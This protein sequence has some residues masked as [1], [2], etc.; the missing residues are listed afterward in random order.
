MSEI[1]RQQD[2]VDILIVGGGSAGCVLAARLSE[3]P[4][5]IVRLLEAGEV[6]PLNSV[7]ADLLD[8]A[9]VPGEPRHDWGYTMRGSAASPAI[10]APR[11][12][13]LGGSSA[14]NAAVAMRATADD[15]RKWKR[16]NL[17]GWSVEEVAAV[18]KSMESAPDG[19]PA[20]HGQTGP[21][22]IRQRTYSGL[23]SS[24]KAF[25]DAGTAA[26]YQSVDDFSSDRH[27]GIGGFPVNVVDGRRQ[28]TAMT[29]LTDA[30]R[31][32]PN[33]TIDGGVLIDRV[34]F[35]DGVA[36]G[37]IDAD[38][39]VYRASEVIL[40][41][42]AYASPA[43]LLRSGV[44]AA[45]ELTQLG[46]SVVADLPVGQRL[47]DHPFYYNASALK[48][49]HLDMT[50]ATGALLWTASSESRGEELD[51]HITATHLFD[52]SLSPTGGAIAIGIAVVSPDSRGT[53]RLR[54]R[55]PREHPVIDSNF[56]REE[57]DRRRMLEG[58]KLSRKL[59]QSPQLGS[60][61]AVE[62]QPGA[63]V[64]GN[65][66][67]SNAIDAG[68]APY[69]HPAS[70]APMGGPE[71]PW[72]VVG[73]DGAVKGVAGLRVIDASIMPEI[74]TVA[75]HLTVIMIAERLAR[76]VYGALPAR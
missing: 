7:P 49:E 21:F 5:R 56:L 38:G 12:K 55:D 52:H 71:D 62:L 45:D 19:A 27:H 40:S 22:P 48:P 13:A 43:I 73:S 42:G 59:S 46:I 10:P 64:Q 47:V 8:P 28:S 60:V 41:A 65:E 66:A 69:A 57:R 34:L 35:D 51:L 39:R 36:T 17:E 50:P 61:L 9:H 11:G 1:S 23:T 75:I 25:I 74:P 32:R 16:H 72:A 30:V 37:V 4:T 14:V 24:L 31:S 53:V 44:G 76:A 63:D 26:G 67:L 6:Y 33:L 58:L 15:I 2:P 68:L 54:S 70:T 20:I 18:F 3:Q 29:Y